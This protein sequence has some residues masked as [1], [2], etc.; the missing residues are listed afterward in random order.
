MAVKLAWLIKFFG[1]E[2]KLISRGENAYKSC[3]LEKFVYDPSTGVLNGGVR[4]S[5]KDRTYSVEVY[6]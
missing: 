4:S 2:P 6:S 1:D 5:L 3:R